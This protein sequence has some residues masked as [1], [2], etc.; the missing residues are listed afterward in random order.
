MHLINLRRGVTVLT[1]SWSDGT[2]GPLAFCVP[3]GKITPEEQRAWNVAHKGRSYVLTSGT[4]SHFMTA[5]TLLQLFE[6]LF[7]PALQQQR[8]RLMG[9]MSWFPIETPWVLVWC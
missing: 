7:S 9:C 5:D 3:D 1:T 4:R 6:Q 8:D 2:R